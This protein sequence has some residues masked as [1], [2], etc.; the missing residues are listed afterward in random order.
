MIRQKIN[1]ETAKENSLKKGFIY[2][3]DFYERAITYI[4]FQCVKCN[5]K[6]VSTYANIIKTHKC[7]NCT[8]INWFKKIN[9][10]AKKHEGECLT[11]PD[12]LPISFNAQQTVLKWKCKRGHVWN[13]KLQYVLNRNKWCDRCFSPSVNCFL[14][15]YLY[16]KKYIYSTFLTDIVLF[17]HNL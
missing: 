10:I 9:K 16:T 11:K 8:K 6:F 4:N 15:Y 1:L 14:M 5:Y 3:D 12:Q 2:L 13:K 17:L 7:L